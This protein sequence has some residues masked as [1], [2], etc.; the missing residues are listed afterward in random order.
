MA[1]AGGN[2]LQRTRSG[3]FQ[4]VS[5]PCNKRSPRS[6]CPAVAGDHENLTILGYTADA[7]DGA[8]CVATHPSDRAVPAQ[9]KLTVP[10]HARYTPRT[11]G[12]HQSHVSFIV[13]PP[14]PGSRGGHR[15]VR[16][17]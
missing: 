14:S 8:A 16:P 13:G 2:L 6:G 17:G 5:M 15:P 10:V 3:Y 9:V 1:T 11:A 12:P 4:D 7:G